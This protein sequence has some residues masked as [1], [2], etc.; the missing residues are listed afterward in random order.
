MHVMSTVTASPRYSIRQTAQPAP[1]SSQ[2][3]A[4][5][6]HFA[7]VALILAVA[8]LRVGFLLCET[9]LSLATDEAHYWDWSRHLDYCYYSKGPLVAWLI[10]ASCWLWGAD[11]MPAV[12]FPAVLCNALTLFGVYLL[13][14]RIFRDARFAFLSLLAAQTLPF[15]HV[16]GL[17]MTIDAPYVCA[18]T[19]A[20]LLAHVILFPGVEVRKTR[21]HLG[22]WILLGMV[23]A[24]GVLAKHNMALFVPTL[25]LFLLVSPVHRRELMQPGFWLMA[26]TGAVLGGG[27][28]LWWNFQ[29][30]WVTF[31]HVGTQAGMQETTGSPRWLGPLEFLAMQAG[32]LLG[33]WFL[34]MVLGLVRSFV[35]WRQGTVDPSLLF[36]SIL[37]LPIFLIC[38]V[39]SFK[40]RIEPNWPIT[41]YITGLILAAWMLRERWPQRLWRRTALGFCLAGL[42][43][44]I[45]VHASSWLYPIHLRCA[46]EVS[47]RKWDASCR[48]KGWPTQAA[49]VQELSDQQGRPPLVLGSNW[50]L[51]GA[52][53]FHLPGQPTV[54]CLGP[55]AGSRHS[56]YDLWRP[57][58]LADPS[59]F[60]GR[61]AIIVGDL[62]PQVRAGFAAFE[63][64]RLVEAREGGLVVAQ[65]PMTLA[66]GFKGAG[67]GAAPGTKH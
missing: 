64:T 66:H 35:Q 18:W 43:L 2:P 58:P 20:V 54:Y 37:T 40:V 36:L 30:D 22:L 5:P 8:A 32:L 16:G 9:S 1:S 67:F 60:A 41:G 49:A 39:F 31:L 47:V 26:L 29:H 12:R 48:L 13:V 10:R 50:S 65:W 62:T 3:R 45:L 25:G 59:S 46:P 51:T 21:S 4:W 7:A 55:I 15:L 38:L 14:V 28:I 63:P 11:T 56:Q 42:L 19:W 52:L 27:P 61:D 33:F 34:L 6:Y 57:N 53:A 44:S 17:L 23:V 24:L